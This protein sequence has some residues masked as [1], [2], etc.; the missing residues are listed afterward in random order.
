M[1]SI[2]KQAFQKTFQESI[3]EFSVVP[4]EIPRIFKPNAKVVFCTSADWGSEAAAFEENDERWN[5][6]LFVHPKE[7]YLISKIEK[8]VGIIGHEVS[9]ESLIAEAKAELVEGY[10]GLVRKMYELHGRDIH[11]F[12][13][14]RREFNHEKIA[15]RIG[16]ANYEG[17]FAESILSLGAVVPDKR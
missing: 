11:F 10:L 5:M 12:Q 9:E 1:S 17:I 13:G 3:L 15:G 16:N 2:Y 6:S 8:P 7:F 4:G 14:I